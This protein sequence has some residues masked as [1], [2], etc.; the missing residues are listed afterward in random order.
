MKQLSGLD[1]SFLNL[2][3][4]RSFGHVSSLAVY[5][6]PDD[7]AFDAYQAFRAQIESKLGTLEPFR[8]R[9]VEVPFGLDRPYWINDP[10]FDIDFHLRHIAVPGEG[11]DQQVGE[12]VGRLIGRP[13]DRARPL[14]EA[15]VIEGLASGDFAVLT[16]LHHSTIDGAA[17][18]ELLA[19]ILD[20]SDIDDDNDW[21]PESEPSDIELLTRTAIELARTP[22]KALRLQ[23]RVLREA[24]RITRARGFDDLADQLRRG[25]PGPAGTVARR[26]LG[27]E[28]TTDP[29]QPP[30]LPAL[31]GPRTPFNATITPH[32]RFAYRSVPLAHIKALKNAAG[33]TVND[34]VMAVC[35]G[36]LRRYLADRDALPDD[37]LIAMVPVSIRTGDESDKWSNRVSA[38]FAEL[39][40]SDDDPLDRLA[41]VHDAMVTAKSQFDLMP[42]DML[43]DM[44]ELAPPALSVRAA[45][46]AARTRI[47]D[48]T[49]PP[50]N[51]VVSNVPGPR[52]VL[53]LRGGAPLKHY[54]PVSTVV[55]GQGLNITVQSYVDSL[56]FGLVSCRELVPDLWALADHCVAE[57][58]VL[59]QALGVELDRV[60]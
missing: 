52:S 28:R 6:R 60:A 57:V 5:G 47:A 24:G 49:S 43:I 4:G 41:G 21:Q 51:L 9:L 50:A 10:D 33:A 36:A 20:P 45:R 26:V 42:A 2:E 29:D 12:L 3:T 32:R 15:Y 31:G 54:Y 18:A 8:R 55:D 40:T 56:D 35:A 1:V 38:I 44:S 39:P 11:D 46:I 37:N 30:L 27:A 16:K 58:D 19:M 48:R 22:V 34:V 25:L 13:M 17:G 59:A 23:V 7:P 53:H 14:W